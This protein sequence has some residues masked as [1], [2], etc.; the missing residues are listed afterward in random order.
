MCTVREDRTMPRSAR[1]AMLVAVAWGVCGACAS[2]IQPDALDHLTGGEDASLE[3]VPDVLSLDDVTQDP[4]APVEL[5]PDRPDGDPASGDPGDGPADSSG[6]ERFEPPPPA[7]WVEIGLPFPK[8]YVF[9]GLWALSKEALFVVGAGPIAYR[10]DGIR[11]EDLAP[12]SRPSVLNAAWGY[13]EGLRETLW[14]VGMNGGVLRYERSPTEP[15]H[16]SDAS[17][18][19]A[20][21][22]FGVSGT[23]GGEVFAVGAKGTIFRWDGQAWSRSSVAGRRVLKGLCEDPAFGLWVVGSGGTVLHQ[24]DGV[25]RE[26]PSSV[27]QDLL[28][29]APGVIAV[30]AGG[31]ALKAD[32]GGVHPLGSVAYPDLTAVTSLPEG[33][34]WAVGLDGQV[35]E[36]Q[37]DGKVVLASVANGKDLFAVH[38][39]SALS[40]WA[41][42][43]GGVA[44]R[45]N[46]FT[47][48][49][50]DTGVTSDLRGF[51]ATG[52]SQGL[53][54]G[55]GG[56]AVVLDAGAFHPVETGTA[57]DL[58]AVHLS[59]ATEGTV[60]GAGGTILAWKEGSFQAVASPTRRDLYAV[61]HDREGRAWAA[62]DGVVL[63][64]SE[65]GIWRVVLSTPEEDL[66]AVYA[67]DST[68]VFAV[69]KAGAIYGYDGK[70]WSRLSVQDIPVEGGQSV[71]FTSS[72]YA[73]WASAPTAVWAAGEAGFLLRSLVNSKTGALEF[74]VRRLETEATLRA[75]HGRGHSDVFVAGG[76][77]TVFHLGASGFVRETTHT[78]ATLYGV[79]ATSDGAAFAVGDTGTVLRR[80]E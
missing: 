20:P 7:T 43:E 56:V 53:A 29:C 61:I 17:M 33:R 51:F 3:A 41:V 72:L 13:G 77:G 39:T 35:V 44:L 6:S 4:D 12:P 57:T 54:V 2:R 73:V 50:K 70:N 37:P 40:V 66:R 79:F 58:F 24:V 15:G 71:P 23:P 45:Y 27:T 46:G 16:W 11:F 49:P 65:D 28:A 30:G 69:G 75:M 59:S 1:R 74:E 63:T 76:G 68:H 60:V 52:A 42:G 5:S 9:K 18:L 64:R 47:W 80:E 31:V 26:V 36:F 78:T 34:A 14:A 48:L 10:Y 8:D 32:A 38:A 19:D 21:T 62:G 67:L 55:V 25:F 22:L